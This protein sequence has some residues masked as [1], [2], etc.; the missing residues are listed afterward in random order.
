MPYSPRLSSPF[1]GEV[2]IELL[3]VM[4]VEPPKR[5]T[6]CTWFAGT[7]YVRATLFFRMRRLFWNAGQFLRLS[8]LP[9]CILVLV[10]IS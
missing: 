3:H 7:R 4:Y 1:S 2:R 6:L 8:K 9:P 5:Y 10:Y